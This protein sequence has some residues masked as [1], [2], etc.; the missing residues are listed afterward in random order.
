MRLVGILLGFALTASAA[1]RPVVR[2]PKGGLESPRASLIGPR[3]EAVDVES[4]LSG[5]ACRGELCRRRGQV[6]NSVAYLSSGCTAWLITPRHVVTNQHCV[7]RNYKELTA[8]NHPLFNDYDASIC[9]GMVIRFDYQLGVNALPSSQYQRPAATRF[10]CRRVVLAHQ[11]LDL[12]ILE[13]DSPVPPSLTPLTLAKGFRPDGQP[14]FLVGHPAGE[15]KKIAY[16]N[17][18]GGTEEL[19]HAR[20]ARFAPGKRA[21]EDPHPGHTV[22]SPHSFV[23]SCDSRG[24]NSGSPLLDAATLQVVGLHWNGWTNCKWPHYDPEGRIDDKNYRTGDNPDADRISDQVRYRPGNT[25]VYIDEIRDFILGLPHGS[26]AGTV[27][28]EVRRAFGG[29]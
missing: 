4:Y 6:F 10:G 3:D 2:V 25:A 17:T 15:P 29:E 18:I 12:A 22:K 27:P 9:E 21:D 14:V 23:H 13:L 1:V 16:K 26:D 24:G 19:C 7:K 8:P 28:I 5:G 11:P 20:P